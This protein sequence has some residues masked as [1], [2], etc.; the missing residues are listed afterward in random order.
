MLEKVQ[1]INFFEWHMVCFSLGVIIYFTSQMFS[2]NILGS[3]CLDKKKLS[4]SDATIEINVTGAVLSPGVYRFYPGIEI[5]QIIKMI[6]ISSEVSKN[7]INFKNK[8]YYSCALH[9]LNKRI[10]FD[11][12]DKK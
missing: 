9:I 2:L 11:A 1:R 5:G 3:F 10:D 7:E 6:G 8:I 4:E 12:L